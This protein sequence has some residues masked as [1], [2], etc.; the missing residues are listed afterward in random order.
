M[1]SSKT[2]CDWKKDKITENF[3][4]FRAIVMNPK[5]A[6]KNCGRVAKDDDFL[7]KPT[8]LDSGKRKKVPKS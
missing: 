8:G 3:D 6:C 1:G 4:K 7:C 5:Y 2:L